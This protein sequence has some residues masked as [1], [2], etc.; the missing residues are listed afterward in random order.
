M[1]PSISA[2]T[3]RSLRA[4]KSD[5]RDDDR[6][7]GERRALRRTAPIGEPPGEVGGHSLGRNTPPW[8]LGLGL[9]LFFAMIVVIA[10]VPS[11]NGSNICISSNSSNSSNSGNSSNIC[12]GSN[13]LPSPPPPPPPPSPV[14]TPGAP[15]YAPVDAATLP[16]TVQPMGYYATSNTARISTAG[17]VAVDTCPTRAS[18]ITCPSDDGT[19]VDITANSKYEFF[20]AFGEGYVDAFG[21]CSHADASMT[22]PYGNSHAG[23]MMVDEYANV[24]DGFTQD[25]DNYISGVASLNSINDMV[26][27][28][29]IAHTC[30]AEGYLADPDKYTCGLQFLNVVGAIPGDACKTLI[31]GGQLSAS[32]VSHWNTSTGLSTHFTDFDLSCIQSFGRVELFPVLKAHL[33]SGT[34]DA[35]LEVSFDIAMG[36]TG[37][38]TNETLGTL[39]GVTFVPGTTCTV[40]MMIGVG[41]P[42]CLTP[43]VQSTAVLHAMSGT[44]VDDALRAG[45]ALERYGFEYDSSTQLWHVAGASGCEL[46]CCDACFQRHCSAPDQC[47][48]YSYDC[49]NYGMPVT[50]NNSAD[51]GCGVQ[52]APSVDRIRC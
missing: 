19:V 29:A 37:S 17:P 31:D 20:F 32:G 45:Y 50:A 28:G 4:S 35:W 30:G 48:Q 38:F 15:R 26:H 42:T 51:Q 39:H 2:W 49:Y 1:L 9:G 40:A 34:T 8:K 43:T 7:V 33:Q 13:G 3:F 16:V 24:A 14:W 11:G 46:G 47:S 27:S 22:T 6:E 18:T 25:V 10:A 41:S 36:T 12:N 44:P 21:S 23:G 52:S 5:D